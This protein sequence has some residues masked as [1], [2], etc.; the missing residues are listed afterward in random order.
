MNHSDNN[1]EIKLW[2]W[3]ERLSF[4]EKSQL[5]IG[6]GFL[7]CKPQYWVPNLAAEWLPLAH[8]L[9]ADL[10]VLS[11]ATTT[12]LPHELDIG[13]GGTIDNEKFAL[14][15][16][17]NIVSSI[18]DT[19]IPSSLALAND[20]ILEYLA[21]RLISTISISWV[22]SQKNGIFFDK[23]VDPFSI[24]IIGA[25]EIRLSINSV[26]GSIWIGLSEKTVLELDGM[27]KRQVSKSTNKVNEG[28]SEVYLEVA[29]LAVPPADI[30]T[31]SQSGTNIDLEIPLSSGL[32]IRTA[33]K[34]IY[35]AEMLNNNGNLVLKSINLNPMQPSIPD[36]FTRISIC[37]AK[38]SLDNQTLAD[39]QSI[40]SLWDTG[41]SFGGDVLML[42]NNEA[43]ASGTLCEYQNR[44]ALSVK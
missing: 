27:W 1:D 23:S 14:F 11:C 24:N 4:V 16:D 40:G 35:S 26:V 38:T 33:E 8:S 34:P 42:V 28:T 15:F 12:K 39:Y 21:M 3:S 37:F 10:K 13:Y 36:G 9:S 32:V 22:G 31:Y 19:C 25:I 30:V 41:I 43:I 44:F 2:N 5:Q 17:H 20:M 18:L 7:S 6:K 29:Q